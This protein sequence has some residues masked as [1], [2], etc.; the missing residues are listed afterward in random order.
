MS[1][2]P[3]AQ[4]FANLAQHPTPVVVPREAAMS[5]YTAQYWDLWLRIDGGYATEEIAEMIAERAQWEVDRLIN[6]TD[7]PAEPKES[8]PAHPTLPIG[9]ASS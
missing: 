6:A 3:H 8:G 4:W 7:G 9:D 2:N 1:V 5:P